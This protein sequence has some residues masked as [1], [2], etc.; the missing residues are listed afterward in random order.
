LLRTTVV[1]KSNAASPVSRSAGGTVLSTF[2]R[3][4]QDEASNSFGAGSYPHGIVSGAGSNEHNWQDSQ[5]KGRAQ[6]LGGCRAAQRTEAGPGCPAPADQAIERS[7]P[8]PRST[9]SAATAVFTA[10]SDYRFTGGE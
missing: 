5:K 1:P 7:N 8:E 9:D 6:Q 4:S 2:S 10:E 3:R